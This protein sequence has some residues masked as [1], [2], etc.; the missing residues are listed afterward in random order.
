MPQDVAFR[1][2]TMR[3]VTVWILVALALLALSAS[4][5]RAQDA[6]GSVVV[7]ETV[8]SG[9]LSGTRVSATATLKV[10]V[11]D[12][13]I[14]EVRLFPAGTLV[15]EP[16]LPS[17]GV[18]F[19][20]DADGTKLLF[21]V[22]GSY[23]VVVP[24]SLEVVTDGAA[25]RCIWPLIGAASVRGTLAI[26]KSGL[27]AAVAGDGDIRATETKGL[28]NLEF[29]PRGGPT[30]TLVWAPKGT[31]LALGAPLDVE[32]QTFAS[33]EA[34]IMRVSTAIRATAPRGG[35]TDHLNVSLPAGAAVTEVSGG[36][37]DRWSAASSADGMRLDLWFRRPAPSVLGARIRYEVLLGSLPVGVEVSP[38][39][40]SPAGRQ[41]GILGIGVASVLEARETRTEGFEKIDV[42]SVEFEVRP[43]GVF[44]TLAYR[45]AN[46]DSRVALTLDEKPAPLIA[47]I[48]TFVTLESGLATA[49]V[50]LRPTF[51]GAGRNHL[52]CTLPG[53]YTLNAVRGDDV[54]DW[55]IEGDHLSISLTRRR[56]GLAE[57][58][59][60][61]QTIADPEKP[62]P[63]PVIRI[64]EASRQ[65]GYLGLGIDDRHE[66]VVGTTPGLRQIEPSELPSRFLEKGRP[67]IAFAAASAEWSIEVRTAPLVPEVRA[68]LA[69]TITLTPEQ[70][71][72][73]TQ[74]NLDV[75]RVSLFD[76]VCVMP[77]GF[78]PTEVRAGNLRDWTYDPKTRELRILLSSDL[79]GRGTILIRAESEGPMSEP[80][81]VLSGPAIGGAK[82][83][84][85]GVIVEATEDIEVR[86]VETEGLE[87]V[88]WNDLAPGLRGPRAYN[89]PPVAVYEHRGPAWS[90]AL[91]RTPI[92]PQ[93]DVT[94]FNR[95]GCRPGLLSVGTILRL[96]I[97]KAGANH[98]SIALPKGAFNATIAGNTDLG[99]TEFRDGSWDLVMPR[100]VKG[101]V[102]LRIAYEIALP[103]DGRFRFEP[104]KVAG[105]N[106]ASGY[107]VLAQDRNDTEV[108][109]ID[110]AGFTPIASNEIP[111]EFAA[112][113]GAATTHLF[114]WRETGAVTVAASEHA[115]DESTLGAKVSEAKIDTIVRA[116]GEVMHDLS[117]M[118]ENSMKQSLTVGLPK[119][120]VIWGAYVW[121]MPVKPSLQPDGKVLIPIRNVASETTNAGIK[122]VLE[123]GYILLR[124]V[125]VER[126]DRMGATGRLSLQAPTLDVNVERVNWNVHLPQGY[127]ILR[128]S[129]TVKLVGM[130][131]ALVVPSVLPSVGASLG[132]FGTYAS[133]FVPTWWKKA[134]FITL[135]VALLLVALLLIGWVVW[136][137]MRWL[138]Y[139]TQPGRWFDWRWWAFRAAPVTALLLVG[140][141]ATLSSMVAG[142]R[143][144]APG[145]WTNRPGLVKSTTQAQVDELERGRVAGMES[146]SRDNWSVGDDSRPEETAGEGYV[147]G[148]AG[149]GSTA[150]GPSAAAG[151]KK[152]KE[153][154]EPGLDNGRGD[155]SVTDRLSKT[156]TSWVAGEESDHNETA[157]LDKRRKAGDYA[158]YDPGVAHSGG[159]LQGAPG[160]PASRPRASE[161]SDE[162]PSQDALTVAGDDETALRDKREAQDILIVQENRRAQ[163]ALQQIEETKKAYAEEQEQS[164]GMKQGDVA[165]LLEQAQQKQQAKNAPARTEAEKANA[166]T[167]LARG[168]EKE[169]GKMMPPAPPRPTVTDYPAPEISLAPPTEDSPTGGAAPPPPQTGYGAGFETPGTGPVP[170]SKQPGS[171]GAS[172]VAGGESTALDSRATFTSTFARGTV[173]GGG[174]GRD[175]RASSPVN[176]LAAGINAQSAAPTFTYKTGDMGRAEGALPIEVRLPPA[177]AGVAR[178]EAPYLGD[179][180]GTIDLVCISRGTTLMGQL[181]ALIALALVVWAAVRRG[182]RWGFGAALIAVIAAAMAYNQATYEYRPLAETAVVWAVCVLAGTAL[183]YRRAAK[184]A[185]R[186]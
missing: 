74:I 130:D 112:A 53:D 49:N 149:T 113:V 24:F 86:P 141:F 121:G 167:D 148:L 104:E 151:S 10:E 156:I 185:A 7:S 65:T 35:E 147:G 178:F 8:Y 62:V 5:L 164:L 85:G 14:G 18:H 169:E 88:E 76:L 15:T 78:P 117:T 90:I 38:P 105:A 83:V 77:A 31:G 93:I 89:R 3:S 140:V 154:F 28:T 177:G 137:T 171:A 67:K 2:A 51:E 42:G 44:P 100:R 75:R 63:I 47:E 81:L 19:L 152:A 45:Y 4:P 82:E 125:W 180:L 129:G 159:A 120:A 142:K 60:E 20:R 61:F 131:Q 181:F 122:S 64:L 36:S 37:I 102:D 165:R 13:A 17:K 170:T 58:E 69:T 39:I 25:T 6:P 150:F 52:A 21:D 160:A 96:D 144:S 163:Q 94:V 186:A 23:T 66:Y 157:D 68:T 109:A 138:L 32:A 80:R 72:A 41:V 132:R 119:E 123:D 59:M 12:D 128:D 114:R 29:F 133:G 111:A 182:W 91:T 155:A 33:L 54:A 115:R 79:L 168:D 95:I 127:H 172:A 87:R 161:P 98:L 184:T 50:L 34:G 146:D 71:F 26:P 92:A 166:V 118:I 57:I 48:W 174:G 16:K 22:K 30:L 116:D 179:Q 27:E 139:V 73:V 176:L 70:A 173:G 153:D 143:D 126:L 134:I 103:A 136:K 1:S 56:T 46:A 175:H 40:V 135:R 145:G 183:M 9:S 162:S 97:S 101:F 84:S 110:P 55:K 99:R 106:L 158:A 11:L 43:S 124:L 107:V 108:T